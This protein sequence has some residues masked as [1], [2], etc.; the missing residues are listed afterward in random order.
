M[1]PL[2]VW[3]VTCLVSRVALALHDPSAVSWTWALS[4]GLFTL[5]LCPCAVSAVPV[6]LWTAT[7][8]VEFTCSLLPVARPGVTV[9]SHT[10]PATGHVTVTGHGTGPFS[11]LTVHT[12]RRGA[13]GEGGVTRIARRLLLP[14]GIAATLGRE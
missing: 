10:G 11:P 12:R 13:G 4:M 6:A 9:G 5:P 14:P 3:W 8:L 7:D 1:C 2:A